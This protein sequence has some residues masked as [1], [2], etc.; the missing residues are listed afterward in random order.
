M[1]ADRSSLRYASMLISLAEIARQRR[2]AAIVEKEDFG[3]C[4][5]L[6]YDQTRMKSKLAKN[7][8]DYI[9]D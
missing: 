1:V 5:K 3:Q 6:F 9:N 8:S 7:T 4:Y 2:K